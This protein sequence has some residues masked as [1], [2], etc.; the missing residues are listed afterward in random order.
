MAG[1]ASDAYCVCKI[2]SKPQLEFKTPVISSC[3]PEWHHDSR[4]TDWAVGDDLQFEVFDKDT[5][6]SFA[7]ELSLQ[8]AGTTED[9]RLRVEVFLPVW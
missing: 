5:L 4:I 9:A 7:G 6:S 8:D 3:N 2:L 1:G